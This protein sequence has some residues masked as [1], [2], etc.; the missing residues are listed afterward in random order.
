MSD[1]YVGEIRLFS[2]NYAPEGW[3]ICDGSL[4]TISTNQILFAL[5]GNTYGGDG[6]TNFKLPDLRGRVIVGQ[7]Q[8]SI[9]G[10]KPTPLTQRVLGQSGGVEQVTLQVNEMP[11]HTHNLVA[12]TNPG[13]SNNPG[14]GPANFMLS[15]VTGGT[16]PI[17]YLP[18]TTPPTG[19]TRVQLNSNTIS[20]ALGTGSNTN[21]HENRMP[22]IALNY[23]I[24]LNGIY[25]IQP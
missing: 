3:S 10:P 8:G 20:K 2:G 23:I 1:F 21:P 22:Y 17:G 18:D 24:A 13:T 9:P 16:K 7:G 14:T 19:I 4:I 5:I 25:P 6:V 15:T 12:T 11:S